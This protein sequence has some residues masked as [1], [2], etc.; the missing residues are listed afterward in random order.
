MAAPNPEVPHI[1]VSSKMPEMSSH[2]KK[3]TVAGI[4]TKPTGI[5]FQR[6]EPLGEG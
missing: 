6:V 5:A 1:A 3:F 4:D 2:A